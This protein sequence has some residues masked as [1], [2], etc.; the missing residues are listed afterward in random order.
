VGARTAAEATDQGFRAVAGP[1]D[2]QGLAALL[3]G[4]APGRRLLWPR[5]ADIAQDLAVLVGPEGP[6]VVP[7]T[8]YAQDRLDLTPEARDCLAGPAPVLLP[9]FSPRS[10]QLFRDA[11]GSVAAP[12]YVAAISQAVASAVEPIRPARLCVSERPDSESL[13]VALATLS[14][15]ASGS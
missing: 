1:G 6:V 3:S 15:P 12:L 4:M 8:V 11:A 5:G 2:A 13:L 14:H 7:A 10:V 9:F